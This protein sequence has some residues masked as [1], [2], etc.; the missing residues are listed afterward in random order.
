M[1]T[2]IRNV[3]MTPAKNYFNG[4]RVSRGE[5][6]PLVR[7]HPLD[8]SDVHSSSGLGNFNA[9]NVDYPCEENACLSIVDVLKS[10]R[11]KVTIVTLGAM[12]NIA[13]FIINYPDL[14]YKIDKIYAMI[15]SIKGKGNIEPFAEFNAYFDPEAL[16]IVAKSGIP[17][18][19]NPMELGVNSVISKNDIMNIPSKN[20]THDMIKDMV[21]GLRESIGRKDDICLY[22]PNTIIN[23]GIPINNNQGLSKLI[24]F[25]T[26][27]HPIRHINYS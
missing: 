19:V 12:T 6:I 22:D 20:V 10:T 9:P 25:I 5:S 2:N 11:K 24:L 27:N 7:E 4:V 13:K 18:I 15:G 1:E 3:D 8:A 21:T 26:I 14:K 17:M 16:D 23:S